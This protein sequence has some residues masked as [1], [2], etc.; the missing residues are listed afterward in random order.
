LR[1]SGGG[2]LAGVIDADFDR[3]TAPLDYP[4]YVLT[5]AAAPSGDGRPA[6]CLVGF[7]TQCSI[8]PPRFLVCLSKANRT[9]RC[10]TGAGVAAVHLLGAGDRDLAALFG[11][12]T[13]DEVDKFERCEWFPGPERVPL[14]SRCPARFV[15]RVEGRTDLGDHQG[16][17]LA[18]VQVGPGLD[19]GALMFSTVTGL[20][21]GHPA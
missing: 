14:L 15:G 2:Y 10:A 16:L 6:G 3:F 1:G 18:P 12:E 21:A 17:L 8:D 13:G 4:M 7:A 19:G 9:Y 20:D 11:T 5:V